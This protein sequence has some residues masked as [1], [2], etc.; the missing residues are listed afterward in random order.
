MPRRR[1]SMQLDEKVIQWL[2]D[3]AKEQLTTRTAVAMQALVEAMEMDEII[4]G[5]GGRQ[6]VMATLMQRALK[7][8]EDNNDK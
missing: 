8:G 3:K 5:L 7:K 4:K 1:I 2:D 6:A